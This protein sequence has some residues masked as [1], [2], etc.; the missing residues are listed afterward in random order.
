M[1]KKTQIYLTKLDILPKIFNET[2][3][4]EGDNINYRKKIPNGAEDENK[5]SKVHRGLEE[6]DGQWHGESHYRNPPLR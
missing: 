5:T 1:Q 6:Q 2:N 4:F 3:N